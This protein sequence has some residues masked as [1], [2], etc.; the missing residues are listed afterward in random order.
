[1]PSLWNV[2]VP[3]AARVVRETQRG[4]NVYLSEVAVQGLVCS[5]L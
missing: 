5:F 2:F 1:M 3:P 4:D